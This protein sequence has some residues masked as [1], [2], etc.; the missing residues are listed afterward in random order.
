MK[1][2]AGRLLDAMDTLN[3]DT[4]SVL[5]V[6]AVEQSC[7]QAIEIGIPEEELTEFVR[8]IATSAAALMASVLIN[9]I[10]TEA[11]V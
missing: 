8:A 6:S 4:L 11:G 7:A 5:A 9:Y 3:H 2:L 10:V 1:D